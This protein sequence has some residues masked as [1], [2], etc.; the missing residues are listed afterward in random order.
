LINSEK[1]VLSMSSCLQPNKESVYKWVHSLKFCM[2]TY[3]IGYCEDSVVC[4]FCGRSG[5][6]IISTKLKNPVKYL[7]KKLGLTLKKGICYQGNMK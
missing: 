1:Y 5:M 3:N 6:R 4:G 2:W 7:G